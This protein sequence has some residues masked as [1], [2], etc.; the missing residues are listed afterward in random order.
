[1][2]YLGS[3]QACR[4]NVQT[5]GPILIFASRSSRHLRECQNQGTTS[6]YNILAEF[7]DLTFALRARGQVG[8]ERSNPLDL[9]S[10]QGDKHE[11]DP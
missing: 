10:G 6:K 3:V 2:A 5:G 7:R 11:I 4:F 8:S 1:M 9:R